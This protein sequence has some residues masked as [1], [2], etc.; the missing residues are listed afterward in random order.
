VEA[1]EAIRALEATG[2]EPIVMAYH[3]VA[4]VNPFLALLYR[5][6]WDAG[7]A[8]IAMVDEDRI[9]ELASFA[10]LGFRTVLH[11]HWLNLPL[12][13]A[14]SA[15]EAEQ[16]AGAFL[17]RLDRFTA[18]GGRI[19]WTVHNIL[20][21]GSRFEAEEARMLAEVA[22][23][24]AVVHVMAKGTREHVAPYYD[25]PSDRVLHV[26]HPSYIGA[27]EDYVSRS[28]ARHDL[29]LMPDEIVYAVVGAIR[30]YKGL[31]MLLDAWDTLP[32]EPIRRLLIAGAPGKEPGIDALIERAVLHPRVVVYPERVPADRMQVLLRAADIAVL[33]YLR[34][35]NSGALMLALTFGLP[36]IVPAGGGLAET[37]DDRFAVTYT[38]D[39]PGSLSDAL[40]RAADLLTPEAR[41]A[42]REVALAHDPV[43]ISRQFSQGL[44]AMLDR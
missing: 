9:E 15:A 33:P 22:R 13:K 23:R 12:A 41:A 10:A 5:E 3:P 11:L 2:R 24:A 34:S 35:L 29:G 1:V 8:P 38:P 16:A 44:R 42:A 17:E 40:V 43:T 36:V 25:I 19:V 21:H 32:A 6:A 39:G 18:A 26:P 7:I 4:R 14:T 28:Q 31:T 37:V 27:Y 30:A 20:A